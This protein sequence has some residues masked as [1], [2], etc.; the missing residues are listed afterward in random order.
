PVSANLLHNAHLPLSNPNHHRGHHALVQ[1]DKAL[2]DGWTY[3]GCRGEPSGSRMMVAKLTT[4]TVSPGLCSTACNSAGFTAAGM[5]Y[6]NECWCGYSNQLGGA[7]TL[8]EDRCSMACSGDSSLKCG[9]SYVNSVYTRTSGSSALPA[10]AGWTQLGCYM[11]QS[12]RTLTSGSTVD[13]S[14][15]TVE[16]CMSYCGTGA[17]YIGLESR[18]ECYCG[19]TLNTN[20]KVA[21]T[22]CLSSCVGDA[23]EICGGSWRLTLFQRNGATSSSSSSSSTSSTSSSASTTTSSSAAATSSTSSLP[24]PAGWSYLG[25]YVDQDVRTLSGSSK[26]SWAGMTP[27]LCGAYCTSVGSQ[28]FGTEAGNECYCGSLAAT[29]TKKADSDCSTN[30]NGDASLKCGGNWR[31]SLYKTA[32]GRW[33]NLGCYLDQSSRTLTSLSKQNWSVMTPALCAATCASYSY[34]GTEAGN[35]CYCGNALTVNTPEPI[36]DC[37]TNCAGDSSL[38]C[39]GNWRLT[40]YY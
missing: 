33:T 24:A 18:T 21:V 22:D 31:L 28:Y 2:P 38:K 1:R 40:L 32:A 16:K 13:S 5:Q 19:T 20:T 17:Q 12:A 15:M 7:T 35:E 39:G 6:G 9:N 34:F 4:S 10:P 26:L 30:C 37:S 29:T 11:D 27:T 25:C 23:S 14:A 8:T 3:L 36:T